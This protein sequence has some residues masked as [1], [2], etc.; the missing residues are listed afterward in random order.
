V[1]DL[2]IKEFM[3]DQSD[4]QIGLSYLYTAPVAIELGALLGL[5]HLAERGN[6]DDLISELRLA[7]KTSVAIIPVRLT[8]K[9]KM[10][11]VLATLK[12]RAF[13]EIT[14]PEARRPDALPFPDH[15]DPH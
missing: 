8:S 12:Q 11:Q 4:F 1:G 13:A 9:A 2:G 3:H 5:A 14:P 6:L 10:R 15:K 7:D